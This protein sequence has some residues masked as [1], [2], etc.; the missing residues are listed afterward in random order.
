MTKTELKKTVVKIKKLLKQQDYDIID[1]GIELVRGLDEPV[2]FEALLGGWCIKDVVVVANGFI[3]GGKL[4]FDK[5]YKGET[6]TRRWSEESIPY[7][8][9]VIWN[10]IGYAPHNCNLHH[11]LN[12]KN[13]SN[14]DS[15]HYQYKFPDG[16]LNF[17]NLKSMVWCHTWEYQEELI[18]KLVDYKYLETLK[19]ID[20]IN[21]DYLIKNITIL[22]K[23]NSLRN[24]EICLTKEIPK[25]I[26][27]LQQIKKIKIWA[28][29]TEILPLEIGCLKNL[30][31]LDLTNI[32]NFHSEKYKVPAE[33]FE[34][35]KLK[36]FR[37]YGHEEIIEQV[38]NFAILVKSKWGNEI[39]AFNKRY[40]D[41]LNMKNF[42][43]EVEECFDLT[44]SND[45]Y[46]IN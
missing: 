34:M 2:V 30:E 16:I 11:S 15:D 22:S 21:E 43:N 40:T 7:Y 33:L 42:I 32:N 19:L 6:L 37:F 14:F 18:D 38:K 41:K 23:I 9:Y 35:E 44:L 28:N 39:I 17:K 8:L 13:I 24:L 36:I 45:S 4:V 12:K 46:I 5:A 10:L 1:S 29:G 25:E 27:Q 3:H 26:Q 31:E 20:L